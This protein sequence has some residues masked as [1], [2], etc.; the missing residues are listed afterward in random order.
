MTR[1]VTRTGT[2]TGHREPP[3]VSVVVPT[4]DRRARLERVLAGL[5]A[6]ETEVAFETIVVSDGSTDGTDEYLTSGRT[7][8]PVV[9][10]R[11]ANAGP[12][13]ARNRGIAAARGELLVLLDDDLVPTAALVDRHVAAHRA[14]P[15][16]RL[17][18]IGPMLDPVGVEL[19]P[20][21]A[22]EQAMLR[23]QYDA[24][25]AGRFAATARQFYSAN[26]SL[27]RA[28]VLEAG[29]FDPAYRRLEDVEL[30]YR[31]E[32]HG[33]VWVFEPGAAGHHHAER[34]YGSWIAMAYDYGRNEVALARR[35]DRPGVLETIRDEH[36]RR[37]PVVRNGLRLLGRRAP[38]RVLRATT[39]AWATSAVAPRT[40]RLT[41]SLLSAT[42]AEAYYRGVADELADGAVAGAG[43]DATTRAVTGAATGAGVDPRD[44]AGVRLP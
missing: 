27:P 6:Q 26:V 23:K 7:P 35:Q 19:S 40:P 39:R 5:A 2:R 34:S 17:V 41:R 25:A 33:A 20:W 15:A 21:V 12:S 8:L 3:E 31:L 14:R 11:Q 44:L 16:D 10:L 43:G 18:V 37:H 32:D 9:A 29:G 28:L 4:F 30:A 22:W 38:R 1:T 42:Y 24:M 36:D 13:T